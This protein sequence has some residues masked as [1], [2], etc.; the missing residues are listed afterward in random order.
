M[1]VTKFTTEKQITAEIKKIEEELN[2]NRWLSAEDR[3]ALHDELD[4]LYSFLPKG[5]W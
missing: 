2:E 5:V 4:Y 3:I 1:Y